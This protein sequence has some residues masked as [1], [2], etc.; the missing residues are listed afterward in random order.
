M[1]PSE[2]NTEFQALIEFIR[3]NRGFDFTGYKNTGLMRRVEKRMQMVNLQRFSDYIDYLEV[4][5]EEFALLFNTILINVTAFFRDFPAW[6][7]LAQDLLPQIVASKPDNQHIRIWSA[8]CASG[9]EAYT[10]AM[11]LAEALGVEQLQQRVKIYAT[12]VDEEALTH[13]RQASYSAKEIEGLPHQLREKYFDLVASRYVFRS[14]PRRA[15]IFGR[16][17]LIQDAPISRLDLLV[18]RNTLMY[19]NAETQGRVLS[20]FH[21]ALN[22]SGFLFLGKAEMLLTHANL[23]TPVHLKFRIFSKVPQVT[24]RNQLPLLVQPGNGESVVAYARSVRLREATFDTAPVAQIVIDL[25]GTLMLV[26]EQ[27]RTLFALTSRDIGRPFRDLELSYRPV[28]LRALI[29]EATT[30]RRSV[31]LHE[32][33]WSVPPGDVRYVNI[34]VVPLLHNGDNLV[35]ISISFIDVTHYHHLQEEL[36]R[37]HQELETAYEELQSTNEEFE[38]TNEELQATVEELETTNEELQSTNEEME[39]MNE[40]LQST[41][42]ELQTTNEEL[43]QRT[44]ELNRSNGFL[45]SILT[46]LRIG[47]VVVD[48]NFSVQIWNR[49]TEDLWGLRADEVVGQFFLNLDIGLPVEQLKGPVRAVING[50]VD[51]QDVLLDA[52]NRRGKTIRCRVTCAP[53][54]S[55]NKAIHGGV[56]LMEE[57]DDTRLHKDENK[58]D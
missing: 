57:W 39:T 34:Q 46:S 16:H 15:V 27:A 56:L 54:F 47:V 51:S 40:E 19:F 42:E 41:N 49:R 50:E 36:Q 2:K 29:E 58:Q 45:S 11:L 28:E 1:N 55:A 5:P 13:A 3:Q 35:G 37:S 22:D 48:R 12:D 14:E 17:D 38:T 32:V 7:Y 21:F 10:L 25:S 44:E 31:L 18:C 9:E 4:H 43:R 20:R 23:F 24:L 33:E 53:L 52:V 26:N 8:G 30:L 6:E